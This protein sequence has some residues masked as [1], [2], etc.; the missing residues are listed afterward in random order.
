MTQPPLKLPDSG[1]SSH[2]LPDG[3]LVAPSAERNAAPIF[4]RLAEYVPDHGMVLEL[5]SGTGQHIAALAGMYPDVAW[6]PSDASDERMD[7]I[8]AWRAHTGA[9]NL[10]DPVLLNA[11]K[12]WPDFPDFRLAYV[13]NLF[14]LIPQQDVVAVIRGA[15]GALATGGHFF[16]YGPFRTDGT[17]RSEGD[18]RFHASLTAQNPLI[19]YKDLEWVEAELCAA[20]LSIVAVHELPANNLVIVAQK[21]A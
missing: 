3:R 19:G 20:G 13:V 1:P 16:I 12:P 17:F 6:Q 5:A 7:S 2:A 21:P 4:E 15:A 18:A 8:N 14:H 10:R 11:S 9:D